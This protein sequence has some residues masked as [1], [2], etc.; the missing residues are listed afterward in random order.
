VV[1]PG[2][3]CVYPGTPEEFS[4]DSSGRG[5][6]LFFTAGTGINARNTTINGVRYD[7]AASKQADGTWVI[8]AAG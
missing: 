5:H 8:E 1:S 2:E 7:F 6:F 4:V 3:S